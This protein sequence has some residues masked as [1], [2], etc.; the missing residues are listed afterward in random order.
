M[1]FTPEGS[2]SQR[3]G[4][5]RPSGSDEE[6]RQ[7]GQHKKKVPLLVDVIQ[8]NEEKDKKIDALQAQ[9]DELKDF[10]K[11]LAKG[12]HKS[13]DPKDIIIKLSDD[14]YISQPNIT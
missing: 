3:N 4:E 5:K 6:S 2:L 9:V 10:I 12:K 1:F 13:I 7:E 11:I 8:E 14:N